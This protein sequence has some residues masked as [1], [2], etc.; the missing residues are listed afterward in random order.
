MKESPSSRFPQTILATLLETGK[1][2]AITS[3]L[4]LRVST[5]SLSGLFYAVMKETRKVERSLF[6][7]ARPDEQKR[8]NERESYRS[9]WPIVF[10]I[11]I[12]TFT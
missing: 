7:F 3:V 9:K 6:F 4:R 12:L 5:V 11:F 2:R 10:S 8:G 1:I